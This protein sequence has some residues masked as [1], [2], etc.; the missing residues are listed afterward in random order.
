MWV[1]TDL[2]A[3]M[4]TA[5]RL[6]RWDADGLALVDEDVAAVPMI[7]VAVESSW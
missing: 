5:S 1:R 6:K 2:Y 7:T 4:V 3:G